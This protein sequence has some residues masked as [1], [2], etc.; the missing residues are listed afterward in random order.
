MTQDTNDE[1]TDALSRR[2]VLQLLGAASVVGLAG[3]YFS[4]D[5]TETSLDPVRERVTVDLDEIQS[6]GT[7]RFGIGT[8]IDSFD[9]AYSTSAASGNV[10]GLVYESLVTQDTAGT[11]YPWLASSWERIEVQDVDESDYEPYMIPADTDADGNLVADEQIL[12]RNP[13]EG[14]VLTVSEA[15]DAV[16]DGTYGIQYQAELHEG[17]TFHNG[18]EMTA[19]NVA[20][21]YEVRENSPLSAQT[22]DSFLHAET[23][24]EYTVNIYGQEPDAEAESQL[25]IEVYPMEHIEEYPDERADPRDDRTPIGTGPF[26]FETYE[27]EQRAEFSTYDDYWLDDMGLD[28]VAWWDGPDAFP[29]SPVVDD[30]VVSIVSDDATRAAALNN[31]EIDLT[32]GL[33]TDTY[34][35]YRSSDEY[36]LSVTDSGGYNFLQYPVTVSPWDDER[37]RKGVNQLLPREQIAENI[38]GGYRTPAYTPLPELAAEEGTADYESLTDELRPLTEQDT[39]AGTE[40]LQEA[41]DDLGVETPI[42]A[43]I[44]TNTSDDRVREAELVAQVLSNTGFFDIDVETYE[45]TAFLQRIL[46]PEYHQMGHIVLIGLSGTF[47]PGSFYDAVNSI[48]NFG[49]CCNFQRVDTPELDEIATEARFSIDA[50]EDPEFRGTQYDQVWRGLIEQAPN[51]YTVFSTN[52]AALSTDY[53]G[54]N[55]YTFSSSMLPYGL[56]APAD[57]QV[58]YLDQE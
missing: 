41:V 4:S 9:P 56:Y 57:Q 6:G 31:N 3:W 2:R 10:H 1:G 49:Q 39:G 24:D 29:D 36:R 28:T 12:V 34:S 35:E 16:A 42:E 32:Y 52:V 40:L 26:E 30:I 18:E 7:L 55:T 45:F 43:T 23:V 46:G 48:D 47:N 14:E 50:V 17:V 38:Y 13:E 22:F 20:R 11:V 21:S 53:V 5:G 54:H 44:E 58:A 25:P 15:P 27:T 33:A 37:I 19:E 8:D 51:S